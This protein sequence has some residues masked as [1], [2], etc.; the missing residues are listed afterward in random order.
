M[1][2]SSGKGK[3]KM[4]RDEQ[5]GGDHY[6]KMKVQPW[7][8]MKACMTPEEFAGYLRG[9]VLSYV[10]RAGHKG[11]ALEDYKK[12]YHV[13]GALIELL[14]G[15]V[16]EIPRPVSSSHP[17]QVIPIPYANIK[18]ICDSCGHPMS[19][20]EP[21]IDGACLCGCS[22]HVARIGCIPSEK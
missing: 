18:D 16:I 19:M 14:Q 4:K 2:F 5:V 7:D 8:A 21:G 12:A 15:A 11:D 3:N 1:D 10:M 6:T 22:T 17:G 13:L 20:H 9:E